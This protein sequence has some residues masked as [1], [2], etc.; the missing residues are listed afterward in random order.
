V[1]KKLTSWLRNS[2]H[3]HVRQPEISTLSELIELLDRFL[4]N[5]ARYPLEWDDFVSWTNQ[6]PAIE[7]IRQRIATTETLFFSQDPAERS[8]GADIVLAERNRAA[9]LVGQPARTLR[10]YD[11]A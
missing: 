6:A 5:S 9:A 8:K 1:L 3:I 10:S 7:A 4:G 2:E 11:A